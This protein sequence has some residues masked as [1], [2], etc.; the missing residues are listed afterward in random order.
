MVATPT[1]KRKL[2]AQRKSATTLPSPEVVWEKL[3]EDFVLPD[4]PVDNINQPALAAALTDSLNTA[5]YLPP[6]SATTTN[7]G[8]CAKVEN[9]TVVKAPDWAWIPAISVP[10]SEVERSYTPVLEGD[11]PVVVMEF[12]SETEGTEYSSKPT[13]PLGKWY[14]YERILQ[15]PNYAIFNL[16]DGIL[17]VYQLE[18]L[19]YKLQAPNKE[20]RYWLADVNLFLGLW[21][22]E[23]QGRSGLWLRWW[24]PEGEQL[25]WSEEVAE[26]EKQRADKAEQIQSKAI[27][28]LI[29]LG[30]SAQQ[31][32]DTLGISSD[33]VEAL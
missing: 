23:R 29:A 32:A 20:G 25:L 33:D 5:G 12:L 10:K 30:L 27:A 16:K 31:I 13:Y 4:D 8:I 21:E 2:Q 19:G 17:E 28:K 11:I 14:Y 26:Q 1:R 9:K 18:D 22:G 15:V 6:E 24:T 3:P 7:Y